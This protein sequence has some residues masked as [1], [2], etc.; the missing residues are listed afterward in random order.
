MHLHEKFTPVNFSKMPFL[1]LSFFSH[2]TGRFQAPTLGLWK[3]S[4]FQ[5]APGAAAGCWA[6]AQLPFVS[7]RLVWE[8][9]HPMDY[10]L[11]DKSP[12]PSPLMSSPNQPL[13]SSQILIWSPSQRKRPNGTLTFCIL[14]CYGCIVNAPVSRHQ[15][16]MTAA[17]PFWALVSRAG[18]LA[19]HQWILAQIALATGEIRGK[20]IWGLSFGEFLPFVL[21]VFLLC[22]VHIFYDGC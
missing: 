13:H 18:S 9:K 10:G 16:W 5:E 8:W 21:R 6:L 12:S 14:Y 20:F 3:V 4:V 1:L 15:V 2:C 19:E 22:F 17:F 11:W 7:L